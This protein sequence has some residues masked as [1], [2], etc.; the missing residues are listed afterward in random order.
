MMYQPPSLGS[1]QM[2]Q[3]E[4]TVPNAFG[5]DHK[6][7]AVQLKRDS[8]KFLKYMILWQQPVVSVYSPLALFNQFSSQREG[9]V[10]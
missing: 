4:A 3:H 7:S 9:K 6:A 10:D 2:Y 8:E 1:N 5:R